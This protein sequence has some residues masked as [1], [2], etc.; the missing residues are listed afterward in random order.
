MSHRAA[1]LICMFLT[2]VAFATA[3]DGADQLGRASVKMEPTD[4]LDAIHQPLKVRRVRL[5]SVS[6][7]DDSQSLNV[8]FDI[9]NEGE[10]NL[11]NVVFQVLVVESGTNRVGAQPR[12]MMGP[13]TVRCKFTLE[14]GNT[15]SVEMR[16][17]DLSPTCACRPLVRIV[18]ASVS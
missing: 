11:S 5:E 7:N 3:S 10:T 6:S 8:K 17:S 14:A 13:F 16:L 4:L 9:V 15:V 12:S 1:A 2:S 18:S